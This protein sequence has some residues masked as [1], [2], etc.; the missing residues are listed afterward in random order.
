MCLIVV[1]LSSKAQTGDIQIA[2]DSII[3]TVVDVMIEAPAKIHYPRKA[4]MSSAVLPGLG[5]IYNK[6]WWKTPFIYGGFAGL[7]Y[8]INWGN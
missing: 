7:G 4:T 8:A 5:Q 2:T 1:L 3:E 6:Q